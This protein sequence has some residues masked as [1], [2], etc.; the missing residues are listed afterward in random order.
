MKFSMAT[1]GVIC[2]TMFSTCIRGH[3]VY[4]DEWTP[5]LD[6]TLSSCCDLTNVYDP[7]AMKVMKAG[8]TVGHLLKKISFNL[9]IVH[10]ER[11]NNIIV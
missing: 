6:A 5:V 1:I 11:R 3:H 7:F 9:L 10:Y 4:Q 2:E 8:S